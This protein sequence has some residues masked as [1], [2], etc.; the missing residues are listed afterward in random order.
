[1]TRI[2]DTRPFI[3]VGI[4]V[5][6][7]SDTRT[8]DDDKSGNVLAQRIVEAGHKLIDRAICKDDESAIAS[9]VTAWTQRDDID[10]V[11]STGG[12]GFTGRD[13]TPD[14]L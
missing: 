10:V 12:T 8:I 11:I 7:V 3:P 5:M 9:Q 14:A 4:A 2:D 13:V 1:M 6:T